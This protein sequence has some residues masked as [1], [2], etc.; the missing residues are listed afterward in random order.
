MTQRLQ[1]AIDV[2]TKLA[3]E[4]QDAMAAVILDE[5]DDEAMWERSFSQSGDKLAQL[6]AKA[7]ADVAA[8]RVVNQGFDEL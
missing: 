4:A 5:L 2:L 7:R 6:A 3:P 1:Q 8:G